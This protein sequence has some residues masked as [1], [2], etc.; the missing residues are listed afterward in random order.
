MEYSYPTHLVEERVP[1]QDVVG[2]LEIHADNESDTTYILCMLPK[3]GGI[4]YYVDR[5]RTHDGILVVPFSAERGKDYTKA[6]D[7]LHR[8][9][10]FLSDVDLV[11]KAE[12]LVWYLRFSA[13]CLGDA[14][15]EKTI[16][17]NHTLV[18]SRA[19]KPILSCPCVRDQLS[20][21]YSFTSSFS[22]EVSGKYLELYLIDIGFEKYIQSCHDIGNAE[23]FSY[24]SNLI[25]D[26]AVMH[27]IPWEA[28]EKALCEKSPKMFARLLELA[29][30]Y[31]RG[32]KYVG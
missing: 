15:S 16:H 18:H 7:N 27:T 24:V 3:C 22:W 11:Q 6:V 30:D 2:F 8:N 13:V 17:V 21:L 1:R 31:E 32:P 4:T 19:G 29:K 20:A 26:Y 14:L 9:I 5:C 25:F 12:S 23:V 10:C 28:S